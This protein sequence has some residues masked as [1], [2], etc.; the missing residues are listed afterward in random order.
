MTEDK[1][2]P[3][4][5]RIRSSGG[6]S[7]KRYLGKLY[8]RMERTRPGV[9]AKRS[10]RF[11]GSRIGR[12]AGVGSAI[13]FSGHPFSS[14]RSRRVAVK[15]RSVRMGG[16]GLAKARAHLRYIQRDGADKNG[17]AGKL[18]GPERDVVD[19][20]AFLEKGKDDRHQF[21]IILSPEEAGELDNLNDFTRDLMAAAEKDLKT[22]L[23]WVAVN[24][25]DT[26]HPHVHIVLRGRTD[27][28]KDLVIARNYITHG[29]R[30][31]AEELATLELGPRQDMDIAKSR[32][33]EV[34]KN[35]FTKLDRYLL[36]RAD[37]NIVQLGKPR[38]PY[39]RFHHNLM[40]ARLRNLENMQLAT[41]EAGDWRLSP[42]LENS[43]KELGRRGDVIRSMG[44]VL[45][46]EF[47]ASTIREFANE[48]GPS[49]LIGRVA[50]T[51]AMDDGHEQR[52]L[53]IEGADGNQWHV[54]VDLEPGA[55]PP[56]G[57]IVEIAAGTATPRKSDRVI[58]AIAERN[59]GVYSDVLHA[60]T[61][62][63][64]REAFRL[65]HKRRLEAL[66]R[67]GIV[68]RMSDGSWNILGDFLERAATYEASDSAAR[69]RTLS[70]VSLDQLTQAH[71]KV[72]L[73][74]ALTGVRE[75]D[76][77]DARFGSDLNS[78]LVA[79]RK[80]LLREGLASD[81][82]DKL[83]IDHKRLQ[84][85]ERIAMNK[86]AARIEK[87]SGKVFIAPFE[88]KP[89]EGVYVRPVDLPSGRFAIVEKAKDFTLVP[90]RKALEAR[91]GMEISGIMRRGGVFW[92]FGK[93]RGGP[94]L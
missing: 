88:G 19:G 67:E 86:A 40:L 9:F 65:A 46:S 60:A 12:G 74:D 91:R 30:R 37:A 25:H 71:G 80:W 13:A 53:A 93:S 49:K 89:V 57:T 78:A 61:D 14:F 18:Y 63:S 66:R 54:A 92:S 64:A 27:D 35:R 26:D 17:E 85:L 75:I 62:P 33:A 41:R 82:S 51:G 16:N 29:F 38:M 32:A 1:F 2:R 55:M 72:F 42:T 20:N 21:R 48:H 3:H 50:G 69:V 79:R 34:D 24:H 84:R 43:L 7:A 70:W 47:A 68:E 23:D 73:D 90:W 15:I 11:T 94:V 31:R 39:D 22:K 87:Q 81:A 56:R 59:S 44:A 10:G 83:R 4:L 8:A 45:G 36:E 52:F 28:G 58:A 6:H 5:G 77:V 76:S